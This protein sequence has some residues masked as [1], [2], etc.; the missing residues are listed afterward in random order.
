MPAKDGGRDPALD[1]GAG[2]VDPTR[3]ITGELTTDA[4]ESFGDE[5]TKSFGVAG[6][7]LVS[8]VTGLM[9]VV[10]AG[11]ILGPTFFANIFQATNTIP[12]LTYNL[13]AGSLLTTLIVP[14]LVAEFEK[15]GIEATRKLLRQIVGV[16]CVG[17][18]VAA[19]AVVIVSP[20]IVHL[21]TIGVHGPIQSAH[22]HKEAW[23]LLFLVLPQIGLYCLVA[24]A[25]AAQN[26]RGHFALAAAAPAIENIGLMATLVFVAAYFG[27]DT[28]NVS[29]A[30]LVCLGLGATGA[31]VMHCAVQCYGAARAGLPLWPSFRWT[32][33]AVRALAKRAV[34]AIGTASLDASW[35]FI[36]V[37]AA[38]TVP[39]GV[40]AVQVGINFYNMP[41]ALSARAVGTVLLPR[42]SREA[43]MEKLGAFRETYDLGISWSWFVAVPA[44]LTLLVSAK[45]IAQSIAFGEMRK[46]DGIA[47]LSASI[48]GLGLALIGATM[49]EFAKQ[50]CYA[51][52]DVIAPLI[53]CAAMVAVLLIGAPIA[54]HA[55]T[56]PRVL[57]SLGICATLGELC[58][59]LIS[60][61]AA[62]RGTH[63]QGTSLATNLFRHVTIALITI[64]PAAVLGRVIQH[65]LNGHAHIGAIIGVTIGVGAG[66]AG[67][68]VLQGLFSA[69]ELPPRLRL[70]SR[71]APAVEG[72]A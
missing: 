69:P 31:V 18:V 49:F 52:H 56:G 32:H 2:I 38:G 33:P 35:L 42:L 3:I 45:P 6:W 58:R 13:M 30:Y 66:L 64:V 17:F 29:T 36:L 72:A 28:R 51:R 48:A 55:F 47:L 43:F 54:V 22:A 14:V 65:A 53:G 63:H 40:V 1:E 15:S 24:A 67:Y 41:V 16:I 23:I 60:D 44:S 62:R 26:A 10:V 5:T 46:S 25:V 59:A 50:A 27:R 20:I 11:A 12:N 68:L 4:P 70:D 8:R 9:R 21:L 7:T 19:T 71:R 39:G 61:R 37:V 34:P 57:L